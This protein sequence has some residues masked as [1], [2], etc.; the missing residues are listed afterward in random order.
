MTAQHPDHELHQLRDEL[1]A[2]NHVVVGWHARLGG[3]IICGATV[4]V[5]MP[6]EQDFRATSD[7]EIAVLRALEI[8]GALS[9]SWP[10][11]PG[12]ACIRD[13]PHAPIREDI[14]AAAR[15]LAAQRS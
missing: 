4:T 11:R 2:R 9:I 12:I 15:A 10:F 3:G 13:E 8:Q 7:A 1:R 6:G 5:R 14:E